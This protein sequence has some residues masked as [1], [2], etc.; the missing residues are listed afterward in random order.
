[1]SEDERIHY[2]AT[3]EDKGNKRYKTLFFLFS[4]RQRP[5]TDNTIIPVSISALP[6]KRYL[7][8]D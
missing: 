4:F 1:M 5:L 8:D 3:T 7:E 6:L 2:L